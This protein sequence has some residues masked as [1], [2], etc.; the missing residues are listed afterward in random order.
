MKNTNKYKLVP[1]LVIGLVLSAFNAMAEIRTIVTG[2][3]TKDM[4]GSVVTKEGEVG[5]V[6]YAHAESGNLYLKLNIEMS[7]TDFTDYAI[8]D[9]KAIVPKILKPTN[10]IHE[11]LRFFDT[12]S[13]WRV[14]GLS[15]C[16]L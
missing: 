16:Q 13:G 5:K 10:A 15:V 11:Y 2:N 1:V 14:V 9:T 3:D 7:S 8:V 12:F 6:V 4:Y